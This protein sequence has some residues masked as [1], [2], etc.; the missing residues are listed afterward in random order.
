MLDKQKQILE[1]KKIRLVNEWDIIFSRDKATK[2]PVQNYPHKPI[3]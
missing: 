1:A 2:P 3:V